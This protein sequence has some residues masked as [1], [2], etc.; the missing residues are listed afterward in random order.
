MY[1]LLWPTVLRCV[2]IGAEKRQYFSF[3]DDRQVYTG[4]LANMERALLT[5]TADSIRQNQIRQSLQIAHPD[6]YAWF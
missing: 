3:A 1:G 2:S 6:V 5:T 4:V